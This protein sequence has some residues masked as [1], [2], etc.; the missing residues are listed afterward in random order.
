MATVIQPT[1]T[2]EI[3]HYVA[4][5]THRNPTEIPKE[6]YPRYITSSPN[7]DDEGHW[8]WI[9]YGQYINDTEL[10]QFAAD[11]KQQIKYRTIQVGDR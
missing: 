5:K 1:V 6:A 9:L 2:A 7:S 11:R 4:I 8:Y 10:Q 3:G